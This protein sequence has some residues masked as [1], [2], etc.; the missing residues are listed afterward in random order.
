MFFTTKTCFTRLG[1]N[2]QH[3]MLSMVTTLKGLYE[4]NMMLAYTNVKFSDSPYVLSALLNKMTI[5]VTMQ[6]I[7]VSRMV[8]IVKTMGSM[9]IS[10]LLPSDLCKIFN[11]S[12]GLSYTFWMSEFISHLVDRLHDTH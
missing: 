10:K 7:K 2:E 3:S 1:I 4:H 9:V 6:Q 5:M 12:Y 11:I 8:N